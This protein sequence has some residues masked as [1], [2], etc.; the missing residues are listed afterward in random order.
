M[1]MR[2]LTAT[3]LV[4]TAACGTPP[5]ISP[6]KVLSHDGTSIGF[7]RTGQGPVVII[8]D[9]A[10][11]HRQFGPSQPLALR[12]KDHFTV[13]TYDRRGRGVSSDTKPYSIAREVEDLEALL[14]EAGGSAYVYGISSGAVLSLEAAA[15]LKGIQ[16]IAL[17]EPP[18]IV[19]N[20]RLP[21]PDDY[22][23]TLTDL[24][25][26]DRRDDAVKLFLT[27]MGTP[28]LVITIMRFLPLWRDLRNAAHT[29]PYDI[30]LVQDY[31]K[32]KP[33]K[34]LQWNSIQI[35]VIVMAGSKSPVWMHAGANALAQAL[36]GARRR[37]LDGQDHDV[38]A[39]VL[40]P[41]LLEFFK[42]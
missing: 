2:I 10:F 26:A 38:Q 36:P 18:F 14:K 35:P 12:L 24:I 41:A 40:A 21:L 7:T 25:A 42:N 23:Q 4:T 29:L 31:Q 16:K 37:T 11:C 13:Y 32:G 5:A 22:L 15:R 9:G 28:D 39:D 3:F 20:G 30:S 1:L 33:L 8:V 17:Y 27:T 19:D 34:P 6:D